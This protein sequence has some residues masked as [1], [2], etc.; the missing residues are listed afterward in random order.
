MAHE[1]QDRG[2]VGVDGEPGRD[3]LLGGDG[4]VVVVHPVLRLAW[5]DEREGE[6]ADALGGGQVDRLALAARHPKRRVRL[7]VRLG[8]HVAGRHLQEL[9]VPAGERFLDHHPRGGLDV[10]Q[11]LVP[12]GGP[13]DAEAVQFGV[14]RGLAGAEVDPP[15]GEQVERVDALDHACRVV[16]GA[17]QQ[18][19]AVPEADSRGALTGGGEEDLGG[20][21]VAVLLEEVV[22]DLPDVVEAEA[23]GQLD[24]LEGV[25]EQ[26]VLVAVLP[27]PGDLVLVED[28]ELH[29]RPP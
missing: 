16:V 26:A 20:R 14:R 10:L 6:G 28:A 22:L 3:A 8:D 9:A 11:P 5:L 21:G 27:G 4:R 18:D 24:L 25:L 1:R 12:L 23:V 19:D 2:Q 29:R 13:L 7:L 15:V 17:R